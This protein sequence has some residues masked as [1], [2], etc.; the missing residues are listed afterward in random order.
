MQTTQQTRRQ[1]LTTAALASVALTAPPYV[2]T[3]YSAGKLAVGL[4]DHWVPGQT[5]VSKKIIEDW[6]KA[7]HI[8]LTLDYIAGTKLAITA[9]GE[10]RAKTGHDIFTFS[11][12]YTTILRDS[13][14]PVDDVVHELSQTY[15]PFSSD[16]EYIGKIEGTWRSVPGPIGSHTYPMVSRLDYFKQYAGVDLKQI[17]PAGPN[18]DKALVESW[19]YDNFLTYCQKLHEAGHAFGNQ[20]GPTSD[21]QDWLGP[22][23]M[24][25][26]SM[27]VDAKGNI[28][29]DSDETRQ[30]LAYMKKLAAYMPPDV[31]AWDDAGN[32]RWIISGKGGGIQNPPSAW[33]VAK[34]TRLD[35]AAQLWH[36]DTPRGP[37][38]RFR[39]SLPFMF[40]LW[41]FSKNKSAAKD[42]LLHLN[43]KEQ[44]D[45]LL[46][47]AQGYDVP[48]N[49]AFANH[50]IWQEVE[51]PTGGQY[52]YPIRGDEFVM[53][54]GYP[55]PPD[56]AAQIYTQAVIPNMVA[57]V[58]QSGESFDAAIKW[59]TS[60]LEG[61][62]RG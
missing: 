26:G 14:E 15:G 43:K 9:Q 1:F 55:S 58:T 25:Y 11:T 34:R 39:G 16:A 61:F 54:T 50:P 20:I 4:W 7:N 59:A 62:L 38:G 45:Q 44:M 18:R 36:H 30:A 60:E 53:I 31:Y 51:P 47:A 22:L 48:L 32:N 52:N 23:F 10:S 27:M 8:E 56:I 37:K 21:S 28:T 33:A 35:V 57:R 3:S 5:D 42:L 29:V 12:W 17:F 40:G 13:L 41:N 2:R 46:A 49:P 6:A 19:N 24:S